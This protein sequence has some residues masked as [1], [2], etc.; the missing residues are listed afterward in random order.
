M[1]DQ[2]ARAISSSPWF[3]NVENKIPIICHEKDEDGNEHGVFWMTVH[4]HQRGNGCP[5]CS[6]INRVKNNSKRWN[7]DALFEHL[8]EIHEGKYTYN[9]DF[10]YKNIYQIIDICCPKHGWFKQRIINHLSGNGCPICRES[11]LEKQ[12][13]RV[14]NELDIKYTPQYR[15]KELLGWQ[16][17]DFYLDELNIAIECQGIQHFKNDKQYQEIEVIQERDDRK[18]KICKDNG[19]KIIYYFSDVFNELYRYDDLF[20]NNTDDLKKYLTEYINKSDH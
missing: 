6:Y 15:N 14:L 16:S 2:S 18:N 7:K 12:V 10:E 4:A 8:D 3:G 13:R 20:F 17:F 5:I 11:R 9:K 1:V 19:I